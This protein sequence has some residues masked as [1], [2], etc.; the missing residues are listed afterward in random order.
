MRIRNK[1]LLGSAVLAILPL[2]VA[3][4]TMIRIT[5]DELK[6]A[7]NDELRAA[8]R[9]IAEGLSERVKHASVRPRQ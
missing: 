9:Q 7:A 3:G 8:A 5:Q 1:L 2:G 6:S 4:S